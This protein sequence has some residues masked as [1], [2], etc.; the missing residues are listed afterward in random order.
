MNKL[1]L[2]ALSSLSLASCSSEWGYKL[3]TGTEKYAPV[4]ASQVEILFAPPV[5]PYK[6]IGIVSVMG[7]TFS[8]DTAM[9]SKLRKAA[10][11]LG[12]DAVIVSGQ[13]QGFVGAGSFSTGS[14]YAGAYP[15]NQGIAIKRQSQKPL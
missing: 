14:F 12:A 9:Y 13:S 11:D 2:L 3:P 6:Q 1:A 7:S 8:S 15:K 10:A 5:T 4:P